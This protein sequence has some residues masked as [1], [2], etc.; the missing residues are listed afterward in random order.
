MS[1]ADVLPSLLP[2]ACEWAERQ[3]REFCRSGSTLSAEERRIASRVGVSRPEAVR[4]AKL[5][6]IPAPEHPLLLAACERLNFLLPAAAGLTLGYGVAL[7][8]EF[9]GNRPLLAHELRHV[10]Q[11][12]RFLSLDAYIE[13]YLQQIL[14]MGYEKC[15][16]EV[17]ARQAERSCL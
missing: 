9:A 14:A 8:L 6:S 5:A 3:G 13:A 12:E 2:L 11:F 7:R 4:V 17:D 10:A 1:D 16:F 15:P